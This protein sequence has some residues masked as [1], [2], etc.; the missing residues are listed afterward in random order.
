[1]ADLGR[2]LQTIEDWD[3]AIKFCELEL[4]SNDAQIKKV[5]KERLYKLPARRDKWM[6]TCQQWQEL[7]NSALSDEAIHAWERRIH[8]HDEANFRARHPS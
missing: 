4:R 1:V 5:A 8:L 2:N 7:K 3:R 6:A